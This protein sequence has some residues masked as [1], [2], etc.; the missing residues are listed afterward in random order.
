MKGRFKLILGSRLLIEKRS[1]IVSL[2]FKYMAKER[3]TKT[4]QV[5][6][7]TFVDWRDA[8]LG[9]RQIGWNIL[10][11]EEGQTKS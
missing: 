7:V 1:R 6:N 2:T 4:Q 8:C 5:W 9:D 10:I 3:T 11:L